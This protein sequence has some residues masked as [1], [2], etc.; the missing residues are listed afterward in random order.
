MSRKTPALKASQ[1]ND[2]DLR[3]EA[4]LALQSVAGALATAQDVADQAGA[5][6]SELTARRGA[7]TR[8]I[9]EQRQRIAR[10]E[11]DASET[12]AKR[13][14]L[15]EQ[16]GSTG[17]GPTLAAAVEAAVAVLASNETAA[18]H[19]EVALRVARQVEAD[20]RQA[21][22]EA[23]RKAEG[24]QT[25]VRTLTNLLKAADNNLWPALVDQLK[26]ERGYE[27]ALGAA[28]GDD[29]DASSD[30]GAPTHWRG[31]PPLE[32]GISLPGEAQ[33][34]SNFVQAPQAL[35]RR[36][37]HIGVVSRSL[38]Q[39]LQA[40]LRSGQRL[41]SREGDVWRWDGF[42]SAADA[43]SAAAKRLAERNRL[44]LLEIEMRD[45]A[46]VA[47]E[48]AQKFEAARQSVEAGARA[49][50]EKREAL[51]AATSSVE[52][53]R[54]ALAR[55]ERQIAERLA[56]TSA[57]DEG[58][59]RITQ[60]LDEVRASFEA[61][62]AEFQAIPVLEGLAQ[63][64]AALRDNVNRERAAYAEARAKHDGL[65]REAKARAE[66]LATPLKPKRKQWGERAKRAIGAD[67]TS[68]DAG[69]GNPRGHCRT[70]R[71]AADS[72]GQAPHADE[73]AAGGGN[74]TQGRGR[75]AGRGRERGSRRRPDFARGPG[76]GL[77]IARGSCALRSP[78]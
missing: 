27:A 14:A 29:I 10:L 61:A 15:L 21:H 44:S 76:T 25:E 53:S 31:L 71:N 12:G 78:A 66:R 6:L 57:L 17:D 42:T 33:P 11:R 56:Q 67:R 45:A 72:G 24:L 68:D 55:H 20:T 30:E 5:R 62:Q 64:V 35:A 40:Q 60:S 18:N 51:R 77:D 19:A 65:E 8:S 47:A 49:E 46:A 58:I 37:S 32:D 69:P 23:R 7:I 75:C 54:Q 73:P 26:V 28:L 50:R 52:V 2:G 63:E 22:D 36:L 9:D 70:R 38:G 59:R 41:V 3:A 13:Q 74:R 34:L 43:P 48:A 16:M 1:N 39:A 4:A